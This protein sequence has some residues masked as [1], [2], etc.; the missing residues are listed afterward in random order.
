MFFWKQNELIGEN[1]SHGQSSGEQ[2]SPGLNWREWEG[3]DSQMLRVY[4]NLRK[5][6][7]SADKEKDGT[8]N[9]LSRSEPDDSK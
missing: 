1:L 6:W 4:E 3:E 8:E 2:G 9:L 7:L 5:T